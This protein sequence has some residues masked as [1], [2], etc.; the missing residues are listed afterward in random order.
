M[1]SMPLCAAHHPMPDFNGDAIAQYMRTDFITLPDHLSVNGA[2]EY[3]VSQ[4]TTDDIP[5]QVFVVAGKALRGVLSIKRLLQE[6][7]TSLNINH[8]TDSCLFHVKPDD[9]RAQVVAELAER[10]V[11]LVAVVE[12]GELVGCLMEKEIAHLQEDDVTEDVQ[13]QGATLPLEKPYLEISPW[14]LWKKRSVWL[15]LLFVAE[16]Y[17][18]SVLQHFEEALES[19]IALAFFIPLLIGTGG[20]SGTQITST[21]VR[22][23]ALGEVRLR[24]MGRVIRKEVSTSLLIALTLGLA[25]CLRAWMMGIG[26]EITLIVSLTL[27]C[28]TLWSAV[29]SSVIPM[30]LKRIGIDPA[31]VSAPFIATLIDGTGL[32]IYFKIAQHFLGLN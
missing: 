24:D 11:D 12:R 31:V 18:S 7:D 21:L 8:L 16:A 3:F 20:N 32:I 5:G 17:T 9:E 1:S 4:L 2:R 27:V 28:I 13:L 14:T 15:L 30:V 6:K 22:S 23:M 10:E 19:A 26:M 25:G 29:V